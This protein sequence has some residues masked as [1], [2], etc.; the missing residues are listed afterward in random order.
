MFLLVFDY[1]PL[2]SFK[3]GWQYP[4]LLACLFSSIP[5]VH[6]L[7]PKAAIYRHF[8]VVSRRIRH[9]WE[10]TLKFFSLKYYKCQMQKLR[11][12]FGKKSWSQMI[13]KC[14]IRR[15][16]AKKNRRQIAVFGGS[17][18]TAAVFFKYAWNMSKKYTFTFSYHWSKVN[19]NPSTH[20]LRLSCK[21]SPPPFNSM[22]Y[23]RR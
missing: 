6:S 12:Y 13:K 22:L 9:F 15:K 2:I 10:I 20:G 7:P 21:T 3:D 17:D 23:R 5:T 19:T 16:M 8:F 18:G 4:L 14:R 1:D 11:R